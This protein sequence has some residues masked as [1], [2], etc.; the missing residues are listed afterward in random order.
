MNVAEET[1][2][3]LTESRMPTLKKTQ[4][5]GS[6]HRIIITIGVSSVRC[7]EVL[8]L[9]MGHQAS[10]YSV[11]RPAQLACYVLFRECLLG[12]PRVLDM[13]LG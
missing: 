10:Q 11:S 2:E 4:A 9:L 13:V 1:G 8:I 7:L 6:S 3:S 12:L 5:P